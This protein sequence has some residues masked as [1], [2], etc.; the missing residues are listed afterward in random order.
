MAITR[1]GIAAAAAALLLAAAGATLEAPDAS[2]QLRLT[3]PAFRNGQPVPVAH[4]CDGANRSPRL[5]WTGPPKGTRSFGLILDDPDAP[6]GTF[7]H[8]T[9]WG[10]GSRAR[11]IAA[12]RP[13]PIEG[14]T[15]F[16]LTGYGGPCPPPGD[17]PHRYR[18]TLYALDRAL[19]LEQGAARGALVVAMKGHV[20][21]RAMLVGTYER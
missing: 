1:P 10:I 13:L 20:L 4:T 7:T 5:V 14:L 19:R 8:W 12:G 17:G 11:S 9:G 3:S 18:F 21:R 15:S 6:G 2:G 16:G